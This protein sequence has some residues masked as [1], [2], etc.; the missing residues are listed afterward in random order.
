[1]ARRPDTT[2]GH[3]A[4]LAAFGLVGT[5]A[6]VATHLPYD[7]TKPSTMLLLGEFAER[8]EP[9]PGKPWSE[10]SGDDFRP[11]PRWLA[12]ETA[13]EFRLVAVEKT[14]REERAVY[15]LVIRGVSRKLMLVRR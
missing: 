6:L 2:H 4:A 15:D 7:V 13:P 1:M 11:G 10:H 5:S 3:L 14:G 8:A 12:E 9:A